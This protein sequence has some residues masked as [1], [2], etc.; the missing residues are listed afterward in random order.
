M[1]D[2]FIRPAILQD[3]Q[4]MCDVINPL[5]A[6]GTTTAHRA[7]FDTNRAVHHYITP[8][9]LISCQVAEDAGRIIGF[10]SLQWWDR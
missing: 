8:S 7:P 10:Q 9:E 3:A 5:I 1:N 2:I 6:Q 4:G